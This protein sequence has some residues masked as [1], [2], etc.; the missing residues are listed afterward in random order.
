MVFFLGVQG[1]S[2]VSP[3]F[4]LRT[5]GSQGSPRGSRASCGSR[6]A[7][8]KLID[9][10]PSTLGFDQVFFYAK[11]SPLAMKVTEE[12]TVHHRP[13]NWGQCFF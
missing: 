2:G 4:F 6:D 13:V 8:D 3:E 1:K 10:L 5:E 11:K 9:D 12:V 7:P